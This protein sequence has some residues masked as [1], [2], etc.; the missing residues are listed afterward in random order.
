MQQGPEELG[1]VREFQSFSSHGTHKL[2]T[3]ILWHTQKCVFC[4]NLT[5]NIDMI[6]IH[7][8]WM[9]LVILVIVIFLLV[10]LSEKRSVPL[11]K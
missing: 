6:F 5:K 3:K 7:S 1:K 8:H 2:I 9:A 4:A 10:S 11:T